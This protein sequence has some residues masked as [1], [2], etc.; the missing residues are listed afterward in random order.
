MNP[1][2]PLQLTGIQVPHDTSMTP[3]EHTISNGILPGVPAASVQAIRPLTREESTVE[4]QK[5]ITDSNDVIAQATTVFPF[6]IVPD[7]VTI[8]RA[9]VT[10]T[11][12]DF[13]KTAEITSYRI[14]DILSASSSVVPFFSSI[15][16]VGRV[17]NKEQ[18]VTIGPFKRAEA[19]RL[20]RIIHGYVIAKQRLID[21]S[22]L[23][24]VELATMLEQ[25]GKD[26]H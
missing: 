24:T 9:K 6:N 16:L 4:L 2:S 25:L 3:R 20:K 14:E 21:T 8:D 1:G 13:F 10:V 26:D 17:M 19:E 11:R 7:T 18:V 5:A 12:R 23:P 22:Q 15:K